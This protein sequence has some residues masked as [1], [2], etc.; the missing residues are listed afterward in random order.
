M[1]VPKWTGVFPAVVTQL[2]SDL[3]IDYDATQKHQDALIREG[4]DGIVILGTMGENNS[5]EPEE[6]RALMKATVEAVGRRVPVIAGVCELTTARAAT[7]ARDAE[8]L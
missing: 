2:A 4:V 7:F 8:R 1:S 5:L 6:K 3:S